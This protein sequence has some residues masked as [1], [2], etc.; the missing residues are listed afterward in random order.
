[1]AQAL[2]KYGAILFDDPNVHE[3]AW[4]CVG[5]DDAYRVRGTIAIPEDHI[6]WSN[7]DA[8]V[9]RNDGLSNR[10]R[11]ASWGPLN[12]GYVPSHPMAPGEKP[13]LILKSS[14][15]T[16]MGWHNLPREDQVR[17]MS[18][19]MNLWM[20]Y[21]EAFFP[22]VQSPHKF[23]LKHTLR[24]TRPDDV[25]GKT[26]QPVRFAA[27]SALTYGCAAERPPGYEAFRRSGSLALPRIE[28]SLR[29]LKATI[30]AN[31]CDWRHLQRS[32][33]P[34]GSEAI[35]EWVANSG[36]LLVQATIIQVNNQVAHRLFNPA[37]EA[38]SEKGRRPWRT[39]EEI[40][41]FASLGDVKI[42]DAWEA[43]D[44]TRPVDALPARLRALLLEP[45]EL[46]EFD[47][48]GTLAPS[49]EQKK[50]MYLSWSFGHFMRDVVKSFMT[51]KVHFQDR[52]LGYSVPPSTVFLRAFEMVECAKQ[53]IALHLE[54]FGV[55]WYGSGIAQMSLPSD[56]DEALSILYDA[57]KKT[58]MLAPAG[59]MP[60][61]GMDEYLE[62]FGSDVAA[63]G[64][65]LIMLGDQS[66]M[67]DL[68][69]ES[70]S[71]ILAIP[72]PPTKEP[73]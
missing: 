70:A 25:M 68:D 5:K 34:Q 15:F 13:P 41:M 9:L 17:K 40:A 20:D 53:A 12:L 33:L 23:G 31:G 36:P 38:L 2:T 63:L 71:Q 1:M 47:L 11:D 30:P 69:D 67:Q 51:A 7:M 37:G 16:E 73:T 58:G 35:I 28:H 21:A 65:A 14:I 59:C 64:R 32:R 27:E 55:T 18:R 42:N 49:P 57:A 62:R 39:G 50:A 22:S 6:L 66:I 19:L 48:Q 10:F 60:Q 4:V 26:P 72:H 45:D 43:V 46:Q 52:R 56:D 24:G 3:A 29:M 61:G 54:G 44:A 8:A